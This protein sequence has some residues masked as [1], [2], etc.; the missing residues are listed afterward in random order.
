MNCPH[1][2]T[3]NPN[4]NKFCQKCG[5]SLTHKTCDECGAEVPLNA[6][7]CQNC[8]AVTGKIW[9]AIISKAAETAPQTSIVQKGEPL[10]TASTPQQELSPEASVT[11]SDR[12]AVEPSVDKSPP[13]DESEEVQETTQP[14]VASTLKNVEQPCVLESPIVKYLDP[15][16]RRYQLLDSLEPE[17]IAKGEVEVRVLDCQ[18]LQKSPLE[19]LLEQQQTGLQRQS[20]S[21]WQ[22]AVVDADMLKNLSMPEIAQA[23]LALKN[24]FPGTVPAIHDGW[25]QDETKV[26]LLEDRSGWHLLVD[27]LPHESLPMGQI[28]YTLDEMAQLWVA[29]EPWHCRQSL[30]EIT[31]LRVD[32]DQKMCLQKLYQDPEGTELT[33]QDLAMMW[34]RLF[35][36]SQRT[37]FDSLTQLLREMYAGDIQTVDEVRS[38]LQAIAH[39]VEILDSA[40]ASTF[41]SST[42]PTIQEPPGV[43]VAPI[44]HGDDTEFLTRSRL[45]DNDDVT[46]GDDMPTVILPMQLI[47]LEDAG[48]TDIGRQRDHNEDFFGIETLMKKQENA[49]GRSVQARGLYIICDG[50]GGHASG[51][52]ASAMAVETIKNYFLDRWKDEL[53][54]EASIREAILV[55]NQAIYDINQQNARSG[56]G[57]MGTTLVM[58]LVQDTKLAL[59]HVGD[60]RLYRFTR[61][62]GLE[63]VTRDHEVG[64]REI[65]RGVEEAIAYSRPD[66]YQLTQALGPRNENFVNPDITFL[67]LHEDTLMI[68]AS[69]GLTDNDLLDNHWQTH[70][71]P[72]ISSRFNLEQGV[73]QLIELAN[74]HNGHDN[75]TAIVVRAKLRPNTDYQRRV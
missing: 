12:D 73:S 1:C 24:S 51:E 60:S 33:L 36:Q 27:L 52:V 6:E 50:M 9:W 28:L 18:P 68:L 32:E 26:V 74:Q 40:P 19:A 13:P 38:R 35:H 10:E 31:N 57:R 67:E 70:I 58:L 47:S 45:E 34:R 20:S 14:L 53:P 66:A 25:Q 11:N 39:E 16:Q 37:K 61:K 72:L 63:Q 15:E 21:V 3:E 54:D 17:K 42:A 65:Q 49:L 41:S 71:A 23:Y 29:L 4:N 69:D 7:N 5:T 75:I 62:K 59:A 8:G 30:L 43:A 64:Q 2:H 22:A 46:G 56:S 44:E 48:E 55:A